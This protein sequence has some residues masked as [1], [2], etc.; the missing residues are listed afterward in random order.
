M[1]FRGGRQ[2]SPA[3]AHARASEGI[4]RRDPGR[5]DALERMI[6]EFGGMCAG[7]DFIPFLIGT[8]VPPQEIRLGAVQL[9]GGGMNG[10]IPNLTGGPEA[11]RLLQMGF[12][13][14]GSDSGHQAGF[15]RG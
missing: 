15:G 14:Y 4:L 10:T 8:R 5:R 13:T 6:H 12:A 7:G 11:G 1:T 9:G 3:S 2:G